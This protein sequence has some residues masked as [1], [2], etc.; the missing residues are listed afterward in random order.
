[1][2]RHLSTPEWGSRG[3]VTLL[4]GCL[5]GPKT[6]CFQVRTCQ[7]SRPLVAIAARLPAPP[8][9]RRQVRRLIAQLRGNSRTCCGTSLCE[10]TAGTG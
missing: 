10:T 3:S 7:S 9:R 1:M 4:A 8:L 6:D 2:W 5:A